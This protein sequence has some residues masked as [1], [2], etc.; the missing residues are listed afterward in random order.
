MRK[1]KQI[2]VSLENRPGRL[3]RFCQY[4]AQKK[5]NIIAISVAETSEQGV[6]RIVVDKPAAALKA[7]AEYGPITRA[8]TDVLL[9]DLPNRVGALGKMVDK[10]AAKR[11]NVDFVYGSTGLA[12]GKSYIV[13]GAPNIESVARAIRSRK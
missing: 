3:S 8:Q 5:I 2:S 13:V 9:I 1:A 4:L 11:I 7:I 12:G 10:L 6:V